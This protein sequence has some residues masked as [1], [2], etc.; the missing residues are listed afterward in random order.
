MCM[1]LLFAAFSDFLSTADVRITGFDRELLG[2]SLVPL[3]NLERQLSLYLLIP[4]NTYSPPPP[5]H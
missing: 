1:Y 5:F 3:R 4:D 2:T